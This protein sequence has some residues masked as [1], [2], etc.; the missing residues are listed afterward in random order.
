M[1]KVDRDSAVRYQAQISWISGGVCMNAWHAK[2]FCLILSKVKIHLCDVRA[3]L[4]FHLC[5]R[6]TIEIRPGSSS[7]NTHVSPLRALRSFWLLFY[8]FVVRSLV[9]NVGTLS[10]L[11]RV[12]DCRQTGH[13]E[14]AR[15]SLTSFD[16]VEFNESSEFFTIAYT[17]YITPLSSSV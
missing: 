7:R 17:R 12:A 5:R 2:V 9:H 8:S 6:I 3:H 13:R 1:R 11:K 10:I 16:L 4:F 15:T 14:S